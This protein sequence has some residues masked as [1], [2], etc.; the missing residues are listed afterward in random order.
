MFLVMG[1]FFVGSGGTEIIPYNGTSFVPCNGDPEIDLDDILVGATGAVVNR[2]P[3]IC[4]GYS[5]TEDAI[6]DKCYSPLDPSRPIVTLTKARQY[7]ASIL[8]DSETLWIT[9]GGVPLDYYVQEQEKT[10]VDSTEYV[11]LPA[12]QAHPGP[13]LPQAATRHCLV[14]YSNSQVLLF[15]G[16]QIGVLTFV[17]DFEESS[18]TLK[19][20]SMSAKKSAMACGVLEDSALKTKVVVATGGVLV[21]EKG[22]SKTT[23]FW[24]P[25]K[26]IWEDGP[27]LPMTLSNA[28]GVNSPDEQAFFVV[29]GNYM[30]GALANTIYSLEC[31]NGDCQWSLLESKLE[32]ARRF[33][34][35]MLVPAEIL[36]CFT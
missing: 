24:Y 5:Q 13:N 11:S 9:G 16:N 7:A 31:S 32:A 19:G 8:L 1:G 26:M 17:F 3:I 6:I 21:T 27:D 30:Q 22:I 18:W 20:P 25:E 33:A 29:G 28:A 35:V 36:T 34:T 15:G 2:A 10:V 12:N 4:G 23:E 14:K